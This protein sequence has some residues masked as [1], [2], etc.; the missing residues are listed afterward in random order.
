MSVNPLSLQGSPVT[1]SAAEVSQTNLMYY[2]DASGSAGYVFELCEMDVSQAIAVD[3]SFADLVESFAGLADVDAVSELD[4]SLSKFQGLFSI[5]IDSDD[6][7]DISATDVLFRV[8][9]PSDDTYND[10]SSGTGSLNVGELF[11]GSSVTFSESNVKSGHVNASYDMATK[12]KIKFDFVRHLAKSITGGYSASDIFTNETALKNGV[13]ATDAAINATLNTVITDLSGMT[14]KDV[15]YNTGSGASL[16]QAARQLYNLNLQTTDGGAPGTSRSDQLLLDISLASANKATV[17]NGE[18]VL[19][20]LNVP[21]RFHSGDR[22]AVRVVYKPATNVFAGNGAAIP[23]RS[24]KIM[25]R[26]V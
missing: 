5:Q 11:T 24:Y 17:V 1:Y 15:T 18:N 20:V 10:C 26:L 3:P 9:Q 7:D 8:N 22:L 6:I 12:Q 25:L 4:V 23:D 19:D 14:A 2:L 21:L 13:S 16:I